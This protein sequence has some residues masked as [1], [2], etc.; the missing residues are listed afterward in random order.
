MACYSFASQYEKHQ[1][2]SSS[3][4]IIT[5]MENWT[6]ED[7]KQLHYYIKLGD[8][9]PHE[10]YLDSWVQ[11]EEEE[12]DNMECTRYYDDDGV[13]HYVNDDD[14]NIIL[15]DALGQREGWR[16]DEEK[17]IIYTDTGEEIS[18]FPYH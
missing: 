18:V 15:D 3:W 16:F 8:L 13:S 12:D 1:K 17:L 6:L 4:L 11:P 14:D 2:D 10:E 7:Y 9:I 5:P